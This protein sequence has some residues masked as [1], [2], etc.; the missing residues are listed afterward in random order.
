MPMDDWYDL[1]M[2]ELSDL[3]DP[4]KE[5]LAEAEQALLEP[6]LGAEDEEAPEPPPVESPRPN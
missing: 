5:K 2:R 1:A 4:G 6:A 3:T